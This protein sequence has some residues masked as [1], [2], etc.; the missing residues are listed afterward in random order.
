MKIH[1]KYILFGGLIIL[2]LTSCSRKFAPS[3]LSLDSGKSNKLAAFNYVYVEAI[4]Q[5]LL[6]NSGNALEYFEQCLKL[7][8]Q[9][10][11]VYYQMA[12]IVIAG[13][14]IANGKRFILNSE[15]LDPKNFWY[16]M[17]LA[18]IYYKEK[19]L[20]S[21]IIFYEKAVEYFPDKED[22]Q[23]T[24]GNL[25]A[26][27]KNYG[28][29][30]SVF[31]SFD[32]KYG[33][34]ETSTLSATRSL[35]AA[36][37]FEGALE[38]INSLIKEFPEELLYKGLLA[39]IYSEKGDNEKSH[40]VYIM[41]LE[42]DA[43]NPNIQLA[44][45][46]FLIK[47]KSYNEL[48]LLLNKIVT[49]KQV[50]MKDVISL[51]AQLIDLPELVT[52]KGDSLLEVL[53]TFENS[54]KD[55]DIVVLLRP[56]LLVRKNDFYNAAKR[57]SEIIETRPDNYYAWEKLLFIYLQER[58]Y[59]N[60]LL[61]GEA[62]ATRFNRSFVAKVL[63]ANGALEKGK[64]DIAL[65]E[66]R[67]AEILAGDNVE[68][69]MQVLT[70]RADIYYRMKNF[71]KAFDTFEEAKNMQDSDLTVLNNYAYYLAEQGTKLNEAEEMAK[72]VIKK[73]GKNTTY[74][75]TYAWVLYKRSKLSEAAKVME[76]IIKSGDKP[77]AI[78]YEHYGY[79]LKKQDKCADAIES[80]K[81]ALRLDSTKIELVKEIENCRK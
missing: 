61:K 1:I 15:K 39:E 76:T 41:L 50:Q 43:D 73:E 45:C 78:W 55:D 47:E 19:N 22:L 54:Y 69:K 56:E 42:K 21:S 35:M 31:D 34:N 14:D 38:K 4:K 51:V 68:N 75:D 23:L 16:L 59:D 28:K 80:W 79:I 30:K 72:R 57:L 33:V 46:D 11:A 63:Y 9:S 58:D 65:D 66:V 13:G 26:E 25:Y 32:K 71:S 18:D 29:A 53:K 6:G 27:N 60:L 77:D 24:L 44:F 3:A 48:L 10:D 37:D 20:D 36:G 40:E 12:Q 70:M 67:K 64:Y 2:Y 81:I 17:S 62:C 52:E 5:K 74:L 8:P 49:N 7:N